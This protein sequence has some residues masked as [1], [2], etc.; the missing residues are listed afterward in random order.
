MYLSNYFL[1][2]FKGFCDDNFDSVDMIL[3][4]ISL[5]FS[6]YFEEVECAVKN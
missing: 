6:F 5:F 3:S 1:Q 4:T 2:P